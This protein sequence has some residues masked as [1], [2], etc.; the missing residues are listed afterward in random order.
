MRRNSTPRCRNRGTLFDARERTATEAER[1]V[2]NLHSNSR[3]PVET[4][5]G[6][7][8]G[9]TRRALRATARR[10]GGACAREHARDDYYKHREDLR[11]GRHQHGTTFRHGDAVW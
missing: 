3:A 9:V 5:A 8:T 11:A 7:I 10:R 4:A 1:E 6:F 2:V